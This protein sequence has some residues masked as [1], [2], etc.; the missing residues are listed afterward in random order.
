MLML[1]VNITRASTFNLS[2]DAR[3]AV[4]DCFP[5]C[6]SLISE[7]SEFLGTSSFAGIVISCLGM[8]FN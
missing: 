8:C 3:Q 6:A 4:S 1:V 5:F 7:I 2:N